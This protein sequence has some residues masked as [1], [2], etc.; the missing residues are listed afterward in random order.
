MVRFIDEHRDDYGVEPITRSCPAEFLDIGAHPAGGE[1][2]L[3]LSPRQPLELRHFVCR[4]LVGTGASQQGGGVICP[5][6]I[7]PV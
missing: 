5:P 7:G 4:R 1:Q 2:L 6:I 3:A